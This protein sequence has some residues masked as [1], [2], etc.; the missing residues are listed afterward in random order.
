MDLH[1]FVL[2]GALGALIA[3]SDLL[4]PSAEARA[5]AEQSDS[6]PR[7]VCPECDEVVV[8]VLRLL[9]KQPESLVVVDLDRSGRALREK[10]Q[11]VEGFVTTGGH[12]VYLTKQSAIMQKAL[13]GPGIWDYALAITVWHEMAHIDG[14]DE[15]EAQLREEELWKEFMRQQRV[16]ANRG[17][18]YLKLLQKRHEDN[19]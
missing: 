8:R 18:N 7:P 12:T 10:Y 17:L 15:R 2:V 11:H 14:A 16:D 6:V 9:P 1:R 3:A 19:H 5:P 4:L 13:A